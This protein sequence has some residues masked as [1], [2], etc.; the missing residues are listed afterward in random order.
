MKTRVLA[1]D[2][3]ST[4]FAYVVL[5]VPERL[6][7]WGVA[8]GD[9]TASAK[10]L[11]NLITRYSPS[12]LVTEDPSAARRGKRALEL[13]ETV[14]TIALLRNIWTVRVP[15]WKVRE[16]F[17]DAHSKQDI[18]VSLAERFPELRPRL[19]RKRKPWTS[20][21]PRMRIFDALALL[22][23]HLATEDLISS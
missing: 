14:Q 2:P 9:E 7:D 17:P 21:D 12:V 22:M 5:E 23:V 19:P 18:A 13:L 4:G 8:T 11:E 1:L 20:E 15:K 16:L 3:T 10:R 6:P